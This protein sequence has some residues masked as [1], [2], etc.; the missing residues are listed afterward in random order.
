MDWVFDAA[1]GWLAGRV[2][3]MLAGLL[4]FLR[5][6]IFVSP[7]VTVFPQSHALLG[8]ATALVDG[9]FV[10]AIVVAGALAMT[11]GSVQIRYEAKD[12]LPR[13]VVAFTLSH[14][15]LEVFRRVVEAGNAVTDALVGRAAAGPEVIEFVR[16]RLAGAL[17]DQYA[18]VLAVLIGLI[19]VALTYLL[20][21]SY[22]GRLVVLLVLAGLAPVALACY[23]LPQTQP[24]AQLWWR[25]LLGCLAVPA[26]QGVVFSAGVSLLL[27]PA[28]NVALILGLKPV[29]STDVVNLFLA[30]GLLW[31]T[32]RVPKLVGRYVTRAVPVSAGALVLRALVI[33]T[34]T[35]GLRVPVRRL[36]R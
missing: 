3:G 14:L 24:A 32:V 10:L 27:D 17:R 4:D 6:T 11:H 5:T 23:C 7:D 33:Q 20:V 18:A 21:V 26:L 36:P 34:V 15:S 30:A 29:P 13:L 22:A 31:L 1:L 28:Y 12:L 35:R 16:A 8:K 2:Q 9:G 25:A 19:I